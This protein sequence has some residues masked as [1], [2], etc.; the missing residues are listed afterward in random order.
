[1]ADTLAERIKRARARSGLT[2]KQLE[3]KVG[4]DRTY[5]SRLESGEHEP[6]GKKLKALADALDVSVDWLVYGVEAPNGAEDTPQDKVRRAVGLLR[7]ALDQWE[8]AAA[9][10][11]PADPDRVDDLI[12]HSEDALDRRSAEEDGSEPGEATGG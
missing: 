11:P 4:W 3:E 12:E 6:G 1:M 7:D 8:P 10:A 2:Q 9:T 5:Q